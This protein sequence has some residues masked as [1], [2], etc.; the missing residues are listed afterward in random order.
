MRP[1]GF[2]LVLLLAGCLAQGT[3]FART[4][5]EAPD[6]AAVDALVKRVV[7]A[8]DQYVLVRALNELAPLISTS[9]H[10]DRLER[11]ASAQPNP[12]I[13]NQLL[14]VAGLGR[15]RDEQTRSAL[16]EFVRRATLSTSLSASSRVAYPP[17]LYGYGLELASREGVVEAYD[18]ARL[19]ARPKSDGNPLHADA[20]ERVRVHL[21]I[22]ELWRANPAA[23]KQDIYTLAAAKGP[24]FLQVARWGLEE[25]TALDRLND[26]D[27]AVAQ[28]QL[29]P[30]IE[31]LRTRRHSASD[32]DLDYL[33]SLGRFLKKHDPTAYE[34]ARGTGLLR[35]REC[36]IH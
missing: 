14:A 2:P 12:L 11:F 3:S 16:V 31:L 22:L 29:A 9:E 7:E 27:R 13:R 28:K 5:S 32:A 18:N 6:R 10:A 33:C 21:S 24:E 25:L 15:Y 20:I 4:S 1:V 17:T 34:S 8:E 23:K 30:V 35:D 26:A 19:L 36:W